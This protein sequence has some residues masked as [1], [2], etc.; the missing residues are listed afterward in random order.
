MNRTANI[1]ALGYGAF[2]VTLWLAS[3]A[4]ADW[5]RPDEN[6][7]LLQPLM[8]VLG[9]CVLAIAGILKSLRA[10]TL[11]TV[12]FLGFAAYWWVAGL[13]QRSLS[14][15]F[16]E[17]SQGWLGWYYVVWAF[18]AFCIWIAACKNGVA[19]MLFTAG[20]CLAL[21]AYALGAWIHLD[22]LNVLGGYL[23]LVTAVVGIYIA[24]A[25]MLN[26]LCGHIVLPLGETTRDGGPQSP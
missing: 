18:L 10:N 23:G 21:L 2:A 11:D 26:E 3:M 24:A 25:E 17:P 14:A 22:A 4:P 1:S 12:L 15:G 5:F 16:V 9:G 8:I 13:A 19:R 6:A 20:L 7:V